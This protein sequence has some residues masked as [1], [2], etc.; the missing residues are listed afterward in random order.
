VSGPTHLT[1]ERLALVTRLAL[2]A[3]LL[4][5]G[6]MFA[7]S[8]GAARAFHATGHHDT[9][10]L[11]IGWVEVVA[12]ALFMAPATLRAGAGL[13]LTVLAAAIL[14][15]AALHQFRADLAIDM[16][17]VSLLATIEERRRGGA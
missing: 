11:A 9:V 2:S 17:V 13:L 12:A 5:G 14:I 6:L 8:A 1:V 16:L 15:H 3:F 4:Y 10:R 7:T